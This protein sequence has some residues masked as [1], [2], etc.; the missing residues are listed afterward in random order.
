MPRPA[1]TGTRGHTVD[2]I[3]T[4]LRQ[5]EAVLPPLV[6]TPA[7][8]WRQ[9]P[10]TWA[11]GPIRPA[12]PTAVIGGWEAKTTREQVVHQRRKAIQVTTAME[13]GMA[14][15]GCS[16]VLPVCE[17]PHQDLPRDTPLHRLLVS[18][19]DINVQAE[20]P[21]H[22]CLHNEQWV[23]TLP[24]L[25]AASRV[26]RAQHAVLT[27]TPTPPPEPWIELRT[28]AVAQLRYPTRCPAHKCQGHPHRGPL[29]MALH[30]QRAPPSELG[31]ALRTHLREH[32]GGHAMLH[33][34]KAPTAA[35]VY[36]QPRTDLGIWFH[37]L[38][39]L[40]T[41]CGAIVATDA[42]TTPAGMIAGWLQ[43]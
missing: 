32:F 26:A 33:P 38:P 20:P 25:Q 34:H 18:R 9:A 17:Q 28:E 5:H 35:H 6:G 19:L 8:R 30:A 14:I 15:M 12:T 11:L 1:R 42:S 13:D 41:I 40:A 43:E 10:K 27:I 37:D 39:P 4:W 24:R 21:L 7:P 22:V 23:T 31:P 2:T 29:Y 3:R 16:V 36:L